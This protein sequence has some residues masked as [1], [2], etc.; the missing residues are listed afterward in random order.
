MDSLN[1][2][3][4]YHIVAFDTNQYIS[5]G[6]FLR[7]LHQILNPANKNF[8]ALPQYLRLLPLNTF[9]W[10]QHAARPGNSGLYVR[11]EPTTAYPVNKLNLWITWDYD[12]KHGVYLYEPQFRFVTTI[13]Y[14]ISNN[15]EDKALKVL[16]AHVEVNLNDGHTVNSFKSRFARIFP[17]PGMIDY[18]VCVDGTKKWNTDGVSGHLNIGMTESDEKCPK[19]KD[20]VIDITMTGERSKDQIGNRDVYGSC[21]YPVPYS[22]EHFHTIECLREHTTVRDYKYAIK[23]K[24]LTS[25][26]KRDVSHVWDYVKAM[27]MDYYQY[28]DEHD[29]EIGDENM[30][31][32]L[33]YPMVGE[34]VEMQVYT[35]QD[36][37][38]FTG[39]PLK[40]FVWSVH[41]PDSMVFSREFEYLHEKNLVDHCEVDGSSLYYNFH[42]V[43]DYREDVFTKEWKTFI[44]DD[45][46]NIQLKKDEHNQFV[47]AVNVCCMM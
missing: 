2:G 41:Q 22:Q 23:T 37:F 25:G 5:N 33:L 10:N 29:V 47:S 3:L 19:D 21:E 43:K 12:M 15:T 9:Y 36:K 17:V 14:A 7:K 30:Q 6:T 40:H 35:Q 32:E 18:Q 46:N 11:I 20:S 31:V 26:F 8:K 28:S 42:C 27:Y 13:T 1:T 44:A 34:K 39:V 45:Q 24:N 16:E 4:H 38:S